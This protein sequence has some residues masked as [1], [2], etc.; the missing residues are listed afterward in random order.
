MKKDK[1]QHNEELIL[2]FTNQNVDLELLYEKIIE[3][4]NKYGIKIEYRYN[5]TMKAYE[6]ISYQKRRYYQ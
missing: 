4:L 6:I 5:K 1:I 3:Y 2:H